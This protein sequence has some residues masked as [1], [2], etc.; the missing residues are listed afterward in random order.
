MSIILFVSLALLLT[1]AA[2][3]HQDLLP[4][5]GPNIF[6]ELDGIDLLKTKNSTET[7]KFE[8]QQSIDITIKPSGNVN[9]N[10]NTDTV[11]KT[12]QNEVMIASSSQV[13]T[14]RPHIQYEVTERVID[15][16]NTR[17]P[18][19]PIVADYTVRP[20][21]NIAL[22]AIKTENN[23]IQTTEG[24]SNIKLDNIKN[25]K[26]KFSILHVNAEFDDKPND[27]QENKV[28]GILKGIKE[29]FQNVHKGFYNGIHRFFHKHDEN[30]G[31]RFQREAEREVMKVV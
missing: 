10:N 18:P 3:D 27:V 31:N 21:I 28:T 2:Q 16:P 4:K 6:N 26:N 25:K 1:I 20:A 15:I 22:P 8:R 30:Q 12:L 13:M 29:Y 17:S 23:A 14:S 19:G 11:N 7:D 9:A 5:V 24:P